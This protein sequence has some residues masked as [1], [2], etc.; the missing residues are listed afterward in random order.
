MIR[1][2][3]VD[4]HELVRIG[5]RHILADYPAIQIAGEAV[6]GESALRMNRELRP[7]VVL[8][9]VSLP[10]LSGF[11]VTTRLK[12]V[13]PELGIVI[14]TVHEQ[15]PYPAQLLAAGASAY[16]TKGCPATELVQAIKTVAR[17]GRHIGSRVA[18][19]MALNFLPGGTASPFAGLSAREM[20]VM[21]MLAEGRKVADIAEV[22]HLSPKTVA[23]YKYRIYEKLNTRSDVDMTRMAMRWGVVAAL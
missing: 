18:Q 21:L 23:T 4:D 8:L 1:V 16:L 7:D 19:Q 15:S 12:Q 22:M 6:D 9:D 13:S 2:L 10:G 17:G 14:L 11:E 3:V 20:E 5:L